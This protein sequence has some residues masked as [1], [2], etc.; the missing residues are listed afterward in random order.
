MQ[1]DASHLAASARPACGVGLFAGAAGS[2]A[3]IGTALSAGIGATA[4]LFSANLMVAISGYGYFA[5]WANAPDSDDLV[6]RGEGRRAEDYLHLLVWSINAVRHAISTNMQPLRVKGML[7]MLSV[8]LAGA[9][10]LAAAASALI[11][12]LA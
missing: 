6:A 4:G 12:V 10:G 2:T 9:T 7:T 8:W 1:G 3:F 11:A 5:A